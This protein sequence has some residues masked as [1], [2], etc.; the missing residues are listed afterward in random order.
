MEVDVEPLFNLCAAEVGA[1]AIGTTPSITIALLAPKDPAAAGVGKVSMAL[2][3]TELLI[4][5]PFKD[6]A[7]VIV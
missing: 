4:V 1:L 6:S 7:E 5:P 2:L 3:P